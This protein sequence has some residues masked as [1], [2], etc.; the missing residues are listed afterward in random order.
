M[1]R[2]LRQALDC[3]PHQAARAVVR[4]HRARAGHL[5]RRY[6]WPQRRPR[7]LTGGPSSARSSSCAAPMARLRSRVPAEAVE[8]IGAFCE[9]T[10]IDVRVPPRRPPLDDY[11]A[12]ADRGRRTVSPKAC[13]ELSVMPFESGRPR[14][15]PAATAP[16]ATSRVASSGP[17]PAVIS[18]RGSPADSVAS[19]SRLGVR[20]HESIARHPAR[21]PHA[22]GAA[23]AARQRRHRR[24]RRHRDQ[25]LGRRH[26]RAA[27]LA[28][29]SSRA[30]SSR[31][32]PCPTGCRRSPDA[33]PVH[34]RLAADDLPTTAPPPSDSR[35]SSS[36]RAAGHRSERPPRPA[37]RPR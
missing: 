32:F 20:I 36:A 17:A 16:I 28:P 33:S 23:H 12:G 14:D 6:G 21:S 30:T 29:R 37:L 5:R 27:T 18:R 1:G 25:R 13:R 4:C 22:R 26:A 31:P 15:G 34:Q 3:H 7:V 8:E 11:V 10:G 9:D 35:I 2:Q 24:P 19:R